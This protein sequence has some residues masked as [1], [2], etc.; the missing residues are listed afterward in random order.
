VRIYLSMCLPMYPCVCVCVCVHLCA[1]L[2]LC[3]LLHGGVCLNLHDFFCGHLCMDV[4]ML[5]HVCAFICACFCLS[6][7]I[8]L[9]L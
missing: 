2:F 3:M 7:C 8:N 9:Y 1:W 6:T 5:L 4:S